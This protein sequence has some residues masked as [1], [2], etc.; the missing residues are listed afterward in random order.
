MEIEALKVI[1]G[2]AAMAGVYAAVAELAISQSFDKDTLL[3]ALGA[4][5]LRGLIVFLGVLK[6]SLGNKE[7]SAGLSAWG[8]LKQV[9]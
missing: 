2:K 1:L 7:T 9:L 5:G 8:W 3:I 4:A 6:D